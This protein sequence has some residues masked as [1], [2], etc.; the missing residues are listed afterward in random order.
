MKT[1]N[2]K[3]R[4]S[5]I[6]KVTFADGVDADAQAVHIRR[7][8]GGLVAGLPTGEINQYIIEGIPQSVRRVFGSW[9]VLILPA[10]ERII[11]QP[12][13]TCSAPLIESRLPQIEIWCFF[14]SSPK[15]RNFMWSSLS[16]VWH[17]NEP[18]PFIAPNVLQKLKA[19]H[20]YRVAKDVNL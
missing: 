18:Y 12:P 3:R 9:P 16:L 10:D 5:G 20:W 15:N 19:I 14:V 17:Q 6:F 7:T 2:R 8:Y 4:S 11:R 1:F 13:R